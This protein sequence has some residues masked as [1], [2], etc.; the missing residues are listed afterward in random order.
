MGLMF[1]VTSFTVF[2]NNNSE[3]V[4][5]D[6]KGGY[7]KIVNDTDEKMRIHTGSGTSTLNAGGGYTS[8]SCQAGKKIYTAPNG[9]KDDL[10][11]EMTS[12]MCGKTV[13]LS[14]YL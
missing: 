14:D 1:T 3:V 6:T 8:V 9:S 13:K 7:V 10:I 4:L 11:F 2:N 5:L 12:D